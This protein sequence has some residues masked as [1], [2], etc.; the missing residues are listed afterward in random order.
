VTFRDGRGPFRLDDVAAVVERS[1]QASLGGKLLIDFDHA[2]DFA[3]P[4]GEPAPAAGWIHELEARADG[5]WG[6]VAWTDIGAQAL[7]ERRYRHLSPVFEHDVSGRIQ[8]LRRASLTNNPA[9]PTLLAV[10]SAVVL[11]VDAVDLVRRAGELQLQAASCRPMAAAAAVRAAAIEAGTIERT[12]IDDVKALA[13][14]AL[15]YVRKMRDLGIAIDVVDAV[16]HI[17]L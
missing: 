5:V 14:A 10:A 17:L 2:A 6:R 7:R 9:T 12:E 8:L 3:A 4:R 15:L 16:T 13:D 1:R 11:R